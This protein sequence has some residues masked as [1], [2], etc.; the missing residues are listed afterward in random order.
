MIYHSETIPKM[1]EG[2]IQLKEKTEVLRKEVMMEKLEA[3]ENLKQQCDKNV[4]RKAKIGR[5]LR[6]RSKRVKKWSRI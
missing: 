5:A 2:I 6:N 1:K 4:K 3:C